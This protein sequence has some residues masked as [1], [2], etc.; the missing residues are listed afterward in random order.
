MLL[1][2]GSP[3]TIEA[4]AARVDRDAVDLAAGASALRAA[5]S[6]TQWLGG[7]ADAWRVANAGRARDADAVAAELRDIARALRRMADEL[8]AEYDALRGIEERVRQW[9][10]ALQRTPGDLPAPW[11]GTRWTPDT[12]PPSG[13]PAWRNVAR[14]L[15]CR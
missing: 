7:R 11:S 5:G 1:P 12:L 15:G 2:L 4:L 13:D 9:I 3:D 8:R 6:R 14:D 10:G